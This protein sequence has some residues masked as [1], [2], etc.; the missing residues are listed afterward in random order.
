MRTHRGRVH[1]RQAGL[2]VGILLFWLAAAGL[3]AYWLLP[4]GNPLS[5]VDLQP[6]GTLLIGD[7]PTST[8]MLHWTQGGFIRSLRGPSPGRARR[9]VACFYVGSAAHDC[10]SGTSV[11]ALVEAE[12]HAITRR[13]LPWGDAFDQLRRFLA[14]RYDYDFPVSLPPAALDVD[15]R[16]TVGACS[17][18]ANTTCT[19]APE[20]MLALTARDLA[21]DRIDDDVQFDNASN[22][23]GVAINLDLRNDGRIG[24]EP[25]NLETR[26]WEIL[27]VGSTD[28]PQTDPAGAPA[29]HIVITHGGEEIPVVAFSSGRADV[30]GIHPPN[31]VRRV[32]SLEVPD[33]PPPK[34]V[35][36]LLPGACNPASG[37]EP[38]NPVTV[39]VAACDAPPCVVPRPGRAA[40]FAVYSVVNPGGVPWDFDP[41]DNAASKNGVYVP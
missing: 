31:G 12:A 40:L 8:A 21:V 27:R 23:T 29:D 34:S 13:E 18:P 17:E 7:I 20:Q 1:A 16:W 28:D 33:G 38:C 15:L 14:P 2:S 10:A 41:S 4:H 35:G 30:L 25:L 19:F 26:V 3:F 9:F 32:F 36:P 37:P 11:V 6:Y 22:A 24:N 39:N 5:P